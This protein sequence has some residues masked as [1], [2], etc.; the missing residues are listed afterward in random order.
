MPRRPRPLALAALALA[1]ACEVDSP[2]TLCKT[3]L[4]EV[5]LAGR[6]DDSDTTVRVELA[7]RAAEG[8]ASRRFCVDDEVRING[9]RAAA[10]RKPSGDTVFALNLARAVSEYEIAL[11]RDG[12]RHA[13]IARVDDLPLEILT[14]DPGAA[15]SR[16]QPF[17]VTWQGVAPEGRTLTVM[18]RDRI[19]GEACLA[20]PYTAEVPD[21]G[22]AEIPAGVLTS[23]SAL[24]DHKVSCDAFLELFRRQESD[25]AVAAGDPLHPESRLIAATERQVD[26][27]LVP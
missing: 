27:I 22:A 4:D 15:L 14:P 12:E 20:A 5:V 13:W 10:I 11:I 24:F 7:F 16:A 26:L 25:L 18:V 8:G 3:P 6:L 17:P 23:T 9:R 21:L 2:A 19:D 1:L